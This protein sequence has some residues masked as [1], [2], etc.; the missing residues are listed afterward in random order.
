MSTR[1]TPC[2]PGDLAGPQAAGLPE[3]V[4]TV[5]ANV[6]EGGRLKAGETLMV[7]GAT[8]GIGVTAIQMGKAAGAK[9]IATARGAEKAAQALALGADIAIDASSEDFED[10][11]QGSRRRRR[12]ARHGRR[13][14]RRRTWPTLNT[15]G[16]SSTSPRSA[17]EP[18]SCR[19][20]P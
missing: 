4:F 18:W 7:H 6:F 16:A 2:L 14:F 8:S 5:Y 15:A 12:R 9:V 3:T 17:A 19:S 13:A 10:A 1:A 11:R 20:A